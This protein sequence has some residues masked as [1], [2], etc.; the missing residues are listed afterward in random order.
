M[1]RRTFGLMGAALVAAGLLV[2]LVARADAL[3]DVMKSKLLRVAVPQDF[4]PF[5]SVDKDLQPRGMDIDVA[6][7]I[8]K[9]LNVKLELVPV[10]SANR[11]PSCRPR[12]SNW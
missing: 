3:D 6:R 10:T 7:L 2:P 8:A 11:I 5:G 9:E 4:A 1:K 12:R